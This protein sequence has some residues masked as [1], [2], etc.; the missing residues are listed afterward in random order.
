MDAGRQQRVESRSDGREL[1]CLG[2]LHQQFARP[3]RG[4]LV[5]ASK[6]VDLL[7]AVVEVVSGHEHMLAHV[8]VPQ[9]IVVPDLQSQVCGIELIDTQT[10]KIVLKL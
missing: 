1:A 2:D 7:G 6:E 10:H 3:L 9:D 4:A 8:L 5:L